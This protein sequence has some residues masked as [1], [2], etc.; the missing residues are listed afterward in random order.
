MSNPLAHFKTGNKAAKFA[1]GIVDNI[2]KMSSHP[3]SSKKPMGKQS[4][5]LKEMLKLEKKEIKLE[6][7]ALKPAAKAQKN[8][9]QS[10]F[11][12]WTCVG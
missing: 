3:K 2:N 8:Y 11:E 5:K 4:K 7:K 12:T 9:P 10:R 6:E 1:T